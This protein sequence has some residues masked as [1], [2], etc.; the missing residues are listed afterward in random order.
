MELAHG[1]I[2]RFSNSIAIK[3][4]KRSKFVKIACAVAAACI[5]ERLCHLIYRKWRR[6]PSGP[7]G[8]PFV[9]SLVP[10]VAT[11]LPFVLSLAKKYDKITYF[12]MAGNHTILINDIDL[13][14]QMFRENALLSRPNFG[15]LFYNHENNVVWT[16]DMKLW[17]QQRGIFVTKLILPLQELLATQNDDSKEVKTKKESFWN[18]LLNERLIS[19]LN[20]CIENNNG[21]FVPGQGKGLTF[22]NKRELN[23]MTCHITF[24]AI[25]QGHMQNY[26][27]LRFD[28]KLLNDTIA[29]QFEIFELFDKIGAI[30]F[31]P[32][33]IKFIM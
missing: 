25:Y 16:N 21:V 15:A 22:G 14:K 1:S 7:I 29:N 27:H 4:F 19:R 8:M 11:P 33:L 2:N 18:N 3:F 10:F 17:R 28:N 5:V 13:M 31:M 23:A 6:F 26:K 32:I 12:D 24:N 30:T 9:G 20:D